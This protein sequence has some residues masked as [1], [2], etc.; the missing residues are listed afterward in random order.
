VAPRLL[1][2][3]SFDQQP[4][5]TPMNASSRRSLLVVIAAATLAVGCE[6]GLDAESSSLALTGS[7]IEHGDMSTQPAD[8]ATEGDSDGNE[9]L[10]PPEDI[11]ALY[12][13]RRELRVL[14]SYLDEVGDYLGL[15]ADGEESE[16]I[17]FEDDQQ[18]ELADAEDKDEA[19]KIH[20]NA[21]CTKVVTGKWHDC[22]NL[23]F[24]SARHRTWDVWN[25][26]AGG[27]ALCA[28]EPRVYKAYYEWFYKDCKDTVT[29][30][31]ETKCPMCDGGKP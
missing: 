7:D 30:E 22:A 26:K 15:V 8:V 4:K 10:S 9:E 1:I 17:V 6:A 23:S 19:V 21:R 2:S 14:S 24:G 5:E 11:V 18:N 12:F 13:P 31:E 25:C 27:T 16:I 28:E 20:R 29:K 3:T